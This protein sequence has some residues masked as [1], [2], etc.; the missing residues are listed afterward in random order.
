MQQIYRRAPMPKYDFKKV[1]FALNLRTHLVAA[2]EIVFVEM[3]IN[4]SLN[5]K[6]ELF[7]KISQY[8]TN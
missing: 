2:S 6:L 8:I 3:L 1:V 4:Y 7:F 5:S